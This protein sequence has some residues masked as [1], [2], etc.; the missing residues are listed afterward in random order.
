MDIDRIIE[1]SKSAIKESGKPFD[2]IPQD[3]ILKFLAQNGV[4]KAVTRMEIY[5]QLQFLYSVEN[6]KTKVDEV[7][8][9]VKPGKEARKSIFGEIKRIA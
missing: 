1:F 7:K 4:D 5:K 3:S 8:E 6:K 9:V 2:K